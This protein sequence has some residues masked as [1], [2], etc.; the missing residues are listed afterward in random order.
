MDQLIDDERR[1]SGKR[2]FSRGG[3]KFALLTLLES[4]PMHG[5]QMMKALEEQSG[6]LYIPSAG[7]IYPTLQ[8]LV[9]RGFTA[10]MDEEG[11]KKVYRITDQGRTA[12]KLLSNK[13][14]SDAAENER[15]APQAESFRNDKIRMKLGLSHASYD[16]L[17]LVKQAEQE[18]SASMERKERL[19]RLINDQHQQLKAFLASREQDAAAAAREVILASK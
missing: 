3:V 12:L 7:S 13:T 18:A 6:G 14:K 16:L 8:M 4:E 17:R 9:R 19:Q 11:G 5:Y 2:Y 10:V 1:G 15:Y